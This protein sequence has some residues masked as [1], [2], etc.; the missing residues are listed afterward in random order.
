M[1]TKAN[2]TSEERGKILTSP[3][4]VLLENHIRA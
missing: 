1:A 3:T 4:V 2:F